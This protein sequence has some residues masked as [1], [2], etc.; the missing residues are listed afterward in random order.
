MVIVRLM[1]GLGNQMFQYAAARKLAGKKAIYIDD[2]FLTANQIST[3]IFT[4]RQLELLTFYRINLKRLN[5][6]FRRFLL[7]KNKL[8]SLL[9][10]LFPVYY[11]EMKQIDDNNIGRFLTGVNAKGILYLNDYFQDPTIFE[12]VRHI[13][14]QDF[15]FKPINSNLKTVEE[16]IASTN[17]VSIHIRRGDYLKP[18]IND[19]HG[20]LT[21]EYY[22]HA[23]SYI[24]RKVENPTYFIF[25]DD[26]EW[27][28]K[29]LSFIENKHLVSGSQ[30]AW[31]DMSLMS[32]CKHQ[33][34][35][36]SSFSWWG[37]WLNENPGKTVICPK[38][39]FNQENTRI[40]PKEW[41]VL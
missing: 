6:Y 3:E 31:E 41:I 13:L 39:W 23:I 18:L 20:V 34:I 36:N 28:E 22:Q 27:C 33:I 29:N 38:K 2:S 40:I 25:S 35:A 5:P 9:R 12:S 24:N 4:A 37:A 11:S 19:F 10:R 14:I 7:T 16:K 1:G 8:L 26:L 21:M 32:R 17:A 15:T 30:A